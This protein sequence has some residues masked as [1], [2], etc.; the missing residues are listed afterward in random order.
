[1]LKAKKRKRKKKVEHERG[2]LFLRFYPDLTPDPYSQAIKPSLGGNMH[3]EKEREG[4]REREGVVRARTSTTLSKGGP[5]DNLG[6]REKAVC[7]EEQ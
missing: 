7:A 6:E 1:M 4:E 5:V 2:D 3:R